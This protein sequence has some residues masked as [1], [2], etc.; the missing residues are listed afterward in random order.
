[1][2]T[3]PRASDIS[4]LLEAVPDPELGSNIVDLGMVGDI[5]ISDGTVTIPIKLT[6]A[7]CPLRG[8]IRDAVTERINGIPGVDKVKVV[9]TEMTQEERSALMDRARALRPIVHP[10]PRSRPRPESSRSRRAKVASANPRSRPISLRRS[11][12]RVMSSAFSTLIFGAF[13]SAV[14]GCL[15]STWRR[16]WQDRSDRDPHHH[17]G[18]SQ[19]RLRH[20]R[21]ACRDDQDGVDGFARRR[22]GQGPDVARAHP[23]KGRRAVPD[24]CSVG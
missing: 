18:S 10:T 3:T 24:R 19:Q 6:I 14:V 22:R 23:C 20:E 2:S 9:T 15:R 13:L 16:G 5:T 17:G 7:S 8:E 4:K 12:G 11:H 1:M 21:P